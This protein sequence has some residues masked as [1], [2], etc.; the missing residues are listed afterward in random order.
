MVFFLSNQGIVTSAQD[1]K[2]SFLCQIV[3]GCVNVYSCVLHFQN[4]TAKV[5]L[6]DRDLTVTASSVPKTEG[7]KKPARCAFG[8][9]GHEWAAVLLTCE[10]TQ[11]STH[12]QMLSIKQWETLSAAAFLCTTGWHC[13]SSPII[14]CSLPLSLPP[15]VHP[16]LLPFPCLSSSCVGGRLETPQSTTR[17]TRSISETISFFHLFYMAYP[18]KFLF[19]LTLSLTRSLWLVCVTICPSSQSLLLGT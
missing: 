18:C 17:I 13:S 10:P 9:C 15:F 8:S 6:C 12:E 11:M 5:R 14:L 3:H 19:S 4:T 16:S 7:K 2:G 1:L